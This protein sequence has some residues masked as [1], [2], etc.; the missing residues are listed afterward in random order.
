MSQQDSAALF[1]EARAASHD[2]DH[3]K[4]AP[5]SAALHLVIRLAFAD[6][7]A[8]AR[9]LCVG[10]GTGPELL[11]LAGAVPQWRFTVVEP[12]APM[13]DLCRRRAEAAG[14]APRCTFHP[15]YLDSLPESEPHDAATSILVSQF[16]LEA[17]Q[18]R[19]FFRQIAGRLRPGAPLVSADLA[20]DMASTEYERLLEVWVRAMAYS[21]APASNVE[22]LGTKVAVL[23][24]GE[25]VSM[26]QAS[27]F[28]S[29]VQVFQ[30]LLVHGWLC[31]RAPGS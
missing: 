7:P 23:P 20:S 11:Y 27:G 16:L 3:A 28:E 26:L 25:I 13:M 19:A 8:Q 30:T 1:D 10:A 2:A 14:I 12:A 22:S 5:M 24:P 6:L 17:D 9:V 18:R 15:D 29:P 21:G 31:R 4:L